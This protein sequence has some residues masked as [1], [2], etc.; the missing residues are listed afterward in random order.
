MQGRRLGKIEIK[1]LSPD[2]IDEAVEVM[3]AAFKDE[4]LTS[5]WLDLTE[6][7]LKKAYSIALRIIYIVHLDS[8]DPIYIATKEGSIVGVAGLKT[9]GSKKNIFKTVF[10]LFKNL[11]Q[12]IRLFPSV[13]KAARGLFNATKPPSSL[14]KNYST[15]EVLA[16]APGQQGKG[17][18]RRLLDQIHQNHFDNNISGIYLVTGDDKNVKIYERFSYQ[19]VEKRVA[20]GLEA[21]HMFK[22]K[23]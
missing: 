14:P 20:K 21:Y 6:P 1:N 15:L 7:K 9:P 8:G 17:T 18:G 2:R 11:P 5:T 22:A 3:L 10:L 12:L 13:V 16:V 19:V 4:S 23:N